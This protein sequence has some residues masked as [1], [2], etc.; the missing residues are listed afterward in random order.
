VATIQ[1][2]NTFS[3]HQLL[4]S[5]ATELDTI[6]VS[7]TGSYAK[8]ASWT[9][10]QGTWYG[11][12]ALKDFYVRANTESQMKT[13]EA[14]SKLYPEIKVLPENQGI[15]TWGVNSPTNPVIEIAGDGKTAKGMWESNGPTLSPSVRDGKLVVSGNW[16]WR[17]YA[18]D[19]A[20]E[21]GQWKIW[22][23][24]I[25]YD[26]VTPLDASYGMDYTKLWEASKAVPEDSSKIKT[27]EPSTMPA[28]TK[29]NSNPYERWS[30]LR[31][32]EHEPKIPEPYYTFS[33]TF[34][35]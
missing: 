12:Q 10:P 19:F 7:P 30:P 17:R 23:M 21:D 11:Y 29:A 16:Y 14:I 20:K 2:Q 18:V 13:L 9:N 28:P 25:V 34:S 26:I 22:H 1:V 6:W 5:H 33:E 8:T 3:K 4:F 27:G 35:Y 15:G 32:V 31:P 24:N